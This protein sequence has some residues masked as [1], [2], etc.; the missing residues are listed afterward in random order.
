MTTKNS[1]TANTDDVYDITKYTDDEIYAILGL[2]NPSDRELEITIDNRI[3]SFSSNGDE[4]DV[5]NEYTK[6]S[7]FF[8]D[9]LDRFFE[10]DD[11]PKIPTT[12][13][14]SADSVVPKEQPKAVLSS[15]GMGSHVNYTYPFQYA[16]GSINALRRET[17]TRM[18]SINSAD[19]DREV[20][21]V[22]TSF[23]CNLSENLNDVVNIK[24]SS[25]KIPNTWYTVA[26]GYGG[27]FLYIIGDIPGLTTGA[28]DWKISIIPGNYTEEYIIT[29]VN[30]SLTSVFSSVTDI[31]FAAG[32]NNISYNSINKKATFSFNFNQYYNESYYYI[33]F[34]LFVNPYGGGDAAYGS[35]PGFLGFCKDTYSLNT[36]YS[37]GGLTVDDSVL[38]VLSESSATFNIYFYEGPDVFDGVTYLDSIS[39]SVSVTGEEETRGSLISRF[40]AA[41]SG[42]PKIINSAFTLVDMSYGVVD[43]AESYGVKLSVKYNRY[44][45]DT[46]NISNIKT[47]VVFPDDAGI[48]VG[49]DSC[50][51]FDV[52]VVE[53]N[54]MVSE[55]GKV[56]NK[57]VV[58]S[59]PYILFKCVRAGYTEIED[60]GHDISFTLTNG[61]YTLGEL[62]GEIGDLAEL[63]NATYPG[64][65][66]TFGCVYDI[67]SLKSGSTPY[68]GANIYR[69]FDNAYFTFSESEPNLFFGS[70]SFFKFE[71]TST[72]ATTT[73]IADLYTCE[74]ENLSGYGLTGASSVFTKSVSILG[75]GGYFP[76]GFSL[77]VD[78]NMTGVSL[79]TDIVGVV[80][81]TFLSATYNPMDTYGVYLNESVITAGNKRANYVALVSINYT[82][83]SITTRLNNIINVVTDTELL[84]LFNSANIGFGIDGYGSSFFYGLSVALNNRVET[85]SDVVDIQTEYD[86]G[87]GVLFADYVDPLVAYMDANNG[88]DASVS[89]VYS[90]DEYTL[91]TKLFATLSAMLLIYDGDTDGVVDSSESFEKD[92][93]VYN[94]NMA[95]RMSM[96]ND[97]YDA[98]LCDPSSVE[99]D[100]VLGGGV[101]SS[102]NFTDATTNFWKE[103]LNFSGISFELS[104]SMGTDVSYETVI[105][106]GDVVYENFFY[107]TSSNNYFYIRASY[108]VNGGV[109]S[110]VANED[111][112]SLYYHD[113]K[114]VL[115]LAVNTGYTTYEIIDSVQAFFDANEFLV[116]SSIS[117][118]DVDTLKTTMRVCINKV[119]S[120]S[121]YKLV[122]YDNTLFTTCKNTLS[123]SVKKVTWDT[124][125]GW[126]LGFRKLS[127]YP[128]GLDNMFYDVETETT[129]YRTYYRSVF[130][131]DATTGELAITGD[132]TVSVNIYSYFMIILDDFNQNHLNDGLITITNRDTAMPLPAYTSKSYIQCDM[133]SGTKYIDGAN[134]NGTSNKLTANQIYAA[135][136]KMISNN[137]KTTNLYSSGLYAKDMMALLPNTNT[138]INQSDSYSKTQERSYFGPVC[139]N[140][141]KIQLINDRGGIVDLNGSEWSFVLTAEIL[142]S[143]I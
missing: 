70:T 36:V 108:D 99:V 42:E 122:F 107:L 132:T 126:M 114:V 28:Y 53:M 11:A 3:K 91:L 80:N 123:N 67:P 17:T 140:R 121:D 35:I 138:E 84:E 125:I 94:L 40:N 2:S 129:Y 10:S 101:D 34:P 69:E 134:S 15:N 45:A 135:N 56:F 65:N 29:S 49:V 105:T 74:I 22:S 112:D 83:S 14:V 109:Y 87:R 72:A 100:T 96:T 61:V 44:S 131:Y 58:S 55:R 111:D 25:V 102:G 85:S 51:G 4:T 38:Y 90:L 86:T 103:Y 124:T 95:V 89:A 12:T 62:F 73:G 119:F 116:G 60:S 52:S 48:W 33:K 47:A 9:M 82:C 139:L 66:S 106:A 43:F 18:I 130:T 39:V 71:T 68:F 143:E 79:I 97:D 120:A 57:Y 26:D 76:S 23:L 113:I 20:Y 93:Y 88:T 128:L 98:Y 92:N 137:V 1:G 63:S 27:N 64:I 81:K 50:F 127:E 117:V 19:R 115:D 13:T 118:D 133:T 31:S 110:I 77:D 5:E 104:Q 7:K 46:V 136:Q 6:I 141:M 142:Y 78:F 41:L 21:P 30:E 32:S 54:D 59:S 24:M 75:D 37:L 16:T 8:E